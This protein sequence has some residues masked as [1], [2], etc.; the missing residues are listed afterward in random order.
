MRHAS[1]AVIGLGAMGAATL[2]Q[3]ARRGIPAIGI[4]RFNPPHDHGS[5]HGETRIT[6]LGVGEGPDFAQFAIRSH[7]IWRQLE[8]ETGERLMVN[9][10]CVLIGQEQDPGDLNK[11]RFFGRSRE[12]A[13]AYGIEHMILDR[14]ALTARFPQFIGLDDRDEAYYEPGAGFVYPEACI[15]VQLQAAEQAGAVILPNTRVTG[16]MQDGGRVRIET[17]TG[18]VEAEHAVVSA[19]AWVGTLLGAPFD[20]LF[21]PTRQV[22]HWFEADEP[23]LYTPERCPVYIRHF[24]HGGG[25]VYG[26]PTP[27]GAVGVKIADERRTNWTDP[28]AVAPAVTEADI[29]AFHRAYIAGKFA[30][31]SPRVTGVRSCLYTEAPGVNFLIDQHPGMD[32]VTVVSACSGH[33]FKH[34]A[35]IGDAIA[36]R[37]ADRRDERYDLRRFTLAGFG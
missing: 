18:V 37:I 31:I 2:Y 11:P 25:H 33:G 29:A 3:L 7:E 12:V 6:R 30:G 15:R 10:G 28:D 8:A 9:C 26:F 5:S 1:V 22:L 14:A 24:A 4:D 13:E 17:A 19:G 34:S 32:R 35:G 23:A 21:R 16:I 27:D 20:R 36:G